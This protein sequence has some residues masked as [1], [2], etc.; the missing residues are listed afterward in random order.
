M[1]REAGKNQ[2]GS[3][4]SYVVTM[5]ESEAQEFL[6][7]GKRCFTAHEGACITQLQNNEKSHK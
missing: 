2:Q 7:I 4:S 5:E 3:I 6:N 1:G